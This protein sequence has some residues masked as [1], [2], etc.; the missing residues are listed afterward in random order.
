MYAV[1]SFLFASEVIGIPANGTQPA[2][3][4]YR[5][6]GGILDFYVFTGPTPAEVVQQYLDVIGLPY[7]PPYWGLGFH[8]CRWGYESADKMKAVIKRMRDYDF[9]YVSIRYSTALLYLVSVSLGCS[10]APQG[11]MSIN[12]LP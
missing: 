6:V 2:K 11:N 3:L 12:M 5:T 4:T 7:M 8:L 9:P 10:S 1:S